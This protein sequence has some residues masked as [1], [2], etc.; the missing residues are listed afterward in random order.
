MNQFFIF[1]EEEEA[2]EGGRKAFQEACR[3]AGPRQEQG[4]KGRKRRRMKGKKKNGYAP[5]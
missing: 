4:R 1:L 2:V 5:G 3:E